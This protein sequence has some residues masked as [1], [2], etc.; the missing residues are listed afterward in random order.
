M[1]TRIVAKRGKTGID[2]KTGLRYTIFVLMVLFGY[3]QTMIAGNEI[4][5]SRTTNTTMEII[6]S[7]SDVI[8]GVQFSVHASG[9]IVIGQLEPGTRTASADWTVA[10]Y[11]PNDSTINVVIMSMTQKNLEA[12]SGSIA[13]INFQY[14]QSYEVSNVDLGNVMLA[15]PHADSVGVT[16]E[17]LRWS[18]KAIAENLPFVL[19]QNYP[20][21]FNPSTQITYRLNKSAQVKL[22]VYDVTGRE[23]RC[24]VDQYQG[25]GDYRVEWN[26]NSN[27]NT[28]LA[29]G[30]YFARLSVDDQSVTRKMVMMK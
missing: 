19:G 26:S 27:G 15:N 28:K 22:S 1:K 4:K 21:P 7:N 13:K 23:V 6:L 12:A 16:I 8:A 2:M 11:K 9:D 30:M 29:S 3:V 25:T 10:S 17:D 24:L 20:N 5:I 18:N 14:A